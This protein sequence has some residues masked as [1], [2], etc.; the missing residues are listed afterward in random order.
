MLEKDK[1]IQEKVDE[2]ILIDK[3]VKMIEDKSLQDS[4]PCNNKKFMKKY[5]KII[6]FNLINN[7]KKKKNRGYAR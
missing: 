7:K 5:Y 3:L 4:I 2:K 6:N 1:K